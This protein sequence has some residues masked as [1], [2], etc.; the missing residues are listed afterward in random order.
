MA[1]AAPRGLVGSGGEGLRLGICLPWW[2]P[3]DEGLEWDAAVHA[4]PLV[5]PLGV[6]AHQG[7]RRALSAS[8]RPGRPGQGQL[9]DHGRPGVGPANRRG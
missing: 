6:V 8:R 5:S 9:A 1:G 2:Q 7:S 4:A 3:F